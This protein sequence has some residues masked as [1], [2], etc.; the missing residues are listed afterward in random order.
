MIFALSVLSSLGNFCSRSLF[1][2]SSQTIQSFWIK[3]SV[4]LPICSI[5]LPPPPLYLRAVRWAWAHTQSYSTKQRA[6]AA[7]SQGRHSQLEN[8]HLAL[9]CSCFSM[10]LHFT[11]IWTQK[12]PCF[13]AEQ[14]FTDQMAVYISAWSLTMARSGCLDKESAG[15]LHAMCS[16]SLIRAPSFWHTVLWG[17]L[18]YEI[19]SGPSSRFINCQSTHP[20]GINS[21][22]LQLLNILCVHFIGCCL[23]LM[24]RGNGSSVCVPNPNHLGSKCSH[25][26]PQTFSLKSPTLVAPV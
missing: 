20:W 14:L 18:E 4:L 25:A 19:T 21:G 11:V 17:C 13:Y 16:V 9:C 22:N 3:E 8:T 2:V 26:T 15:I 5:S 24:S 23:V 12:E 7:L 1:I 10:H 6:K